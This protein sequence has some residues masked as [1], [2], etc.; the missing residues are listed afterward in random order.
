MGIR[1]LAVEEEELLEIERISKTFRDT[2]GYGRLAE[3]LAKRSIPYLISRL[4][5]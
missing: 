2:L 3:S 5:P 1:K 4:K